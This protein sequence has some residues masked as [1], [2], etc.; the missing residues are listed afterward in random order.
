MGRTIHRL[1]SNK[2]WVLPTSI[3]R[4]RGSTKLMEHWALA[5][6]LSVVLYQGIN[7]SLHVPSPRVSKVIVTPQSQ[8]WLSSTRTLSKTRTCTT[9]FTLSSSLCVKGLTRGLTCTWHLGLYVGETQS[10]LDSISTSKVGQLPTHVMPLTFGSLV[11]SNSSL[12]SRDVTEYLGNK[13][14]PD[15]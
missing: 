15:I 4:W 11:G 6:F 9:P 13:E 7:I 1:Q 5:M 12:L 10:Q 2:T 3:S 8:I 14:W